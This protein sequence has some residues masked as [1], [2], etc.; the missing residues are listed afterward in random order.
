[1]AV[2]GY[3]QVTRRFISALSAA[4]RAARNAS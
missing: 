2:L 4:S 1:V 3:E